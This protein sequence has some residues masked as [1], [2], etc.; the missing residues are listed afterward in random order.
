MIT[1]ISRIFR[2]GLKNFWRNGWLTTVTIVIMT[3]ALLVFFGLIV[4][5][6]VT[7]QAIASIQ[8]KIDISVYF[9]TNTSEDQ[10]LNIK[11]SVESLSEVKVVDY[12][13]SDKALEVFKAAHK[14]DAT[15]SQAVSELSENP[16]ESSLTIK[17]NNPSQYA[18]IAG[19][20]ES[21][22]LKRFISSV[23]YAKNQ[24]VINRLNVIL[25]NINRMGLGMT[26]AISLI[27]GLVV[28][29]TIRL[30]IYSN[31]E[32]IGVMRVVGAS[33]VLVRGPYVIEGIFSGLIAAVLSLLVAWPIVQFVSPYLSSFI[34][35]L[36][37]SNYFYANIFSLLGYQGLF[38][39][40]IGVFSSFIAVRR[41]LKN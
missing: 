29:N 12:I 11:K 4:F 41:Y 19:Y 37:I 18:S 16:L 20:L 28:F 35:G 21:P 25:K 40:G 13:S 30:A 17:A 33:N 23:S 36:Q 7:D 34:P 2:Y 8:D 15:I 27:A 24:V 32:E 5:N 1:I 14:D 26:V 31:R 39:V 6:V 9:K 3:M 38:G 10:I 22:N